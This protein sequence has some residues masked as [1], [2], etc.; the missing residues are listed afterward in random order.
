MPRWLVLGLAVTFAVLYVAA[1][2]GSIYVMG[3]F[4][5]KYW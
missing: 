5:I 4:V 3:H 2:I 1:V